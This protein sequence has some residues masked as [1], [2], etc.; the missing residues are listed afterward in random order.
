MVIILYS[1]AFFSNPEKTSLLKNY[2]FLILFEILVIT[3]FHAFWLLPAIIVDSISLPQG[4]SAIESVKFFSFARF[5]HGFT[6]M[7]PNFPDNVFGKVNE[8]SGL[9]FL[10]PLLAFSGLKANRKAVLYF[11]VIALVSAFFIKGTNEPFGDVYEW[12]FKNIPTFNWFRDS[13]KFFAPFSIAYTLLIGM[14]TEIL[15]KYAVKKSIFLFVVCTGM[16]LI[17]W[18]PIYTGKINGTLTYRNTPE[19]LNVIDNVVSS[20]KSFGRIL[21]IPSREMYG[22]EDINHP[23]ISLTSLRRQPTC[24]QV[25]CIQNPKKYE[26][27]FTID[28]AKEEIDQDLAFLLDPYTE[29]I[30]RS[31]GINYIIQSPDIDKSLYIY[32]RKFAPWMK[33]YYTQKITQVSWLQNPVVPNLYKLKEKTSLVHNSDDIRFIPFKV[34]MVSPIEYEVDL[35]DNKSNIIF[36][37]AYNNQWILKQDDETIYSVPDRHGMTSFPFGNTKIGKATIYF[38]GQEIA[39]SGWIVSII[40]IAI[41][42]GLICIINIKRHKNEIAG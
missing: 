7:H 33:E 26:K 23:A 35:T 38:K 5:S 30:F 1:G 2:I 20:D 22:Y 40:S 28:N 32:D 13:T 3:G 21:W 36:A 37:Q 14:S 15:F 6:W 16:F 27:E 12:L 24:L 9:V 4:Y 10:I 8:V 19:G 29:T 39:Y 34:K 25:F 41:T 18:M 31:L 11:S 17:V 42:I